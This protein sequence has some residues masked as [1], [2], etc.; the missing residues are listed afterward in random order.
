MHT[1]LGPDSAERSDPRV[2]GACVGQGAAMSD[3]SNNP[4]SIR[5]EFADDPDMQ[6]LVL[7]YINKMELRVEKMTAAYEQGEREQLIRLAHQLKG[8]GGGYGFPIL[9]TL[10]GELEKTLLSLGEGDLDQAAKPFSALLDV[11]GRMAA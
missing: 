2:I 5:S 6:D 9:T 4:A 1:P 11:C 8:S 3:S 7:E 10:A